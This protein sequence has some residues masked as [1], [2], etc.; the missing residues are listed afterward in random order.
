MAIIDR[1]TDAAEREYLLLTDYKTPYFYPGQLHFVEN[2]S[3]AVL[4]R[5]KGWHLHH[6]AELNPDGTTNKTR[7]R[8]IMEN[9]YYYRPASELIF[10]RATEHSKMHAHALHLSGKRS[11]SR[12]ETRKKQSDAKLKSNNTEK[13]YGVVSG[14]VA[15][16]ETL[17]FTDY[18]FY[19]RYCQRNG[20]PFTG[21][22]VDKT[23]TLK[24]VDVPRIVSSKNI[25]IRADR[26]RERFRSIMRTLS[27]GGK[28]SRGDYSFLR[29][30]CV[31]NSIELPDVQISYA[32]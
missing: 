7:E 24:R 26:Q 15:R 11:K 23:G 14:M 16:G 8:M 1:Y 29:R 21:A 6:R 2:F 17:S 20:L 10:L 13:R 32:P 25:P 3:S 19:R 27:D 22:K 4:D 28:I 31:R 9:I 30:Y 5:F 12:A 18:A